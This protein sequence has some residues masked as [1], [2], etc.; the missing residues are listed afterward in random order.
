MDAEDSLD[1]NLEYLNNE[2]IQQ[3]SEKHPKLS[4]DNLKLC[5][6]ENENVI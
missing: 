2:F 5:Y 1:R 3:I 4:I 6:L